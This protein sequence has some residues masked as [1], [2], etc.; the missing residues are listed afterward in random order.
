MGV[1]EKPY[2]IQ[3][4]TFLS[5]LEYLEIK[6]QQFTI[7]VIKTILLF[8]SQS[9]SKHYLLEVYDEKPK[10]GNWS[11]GVGV[12]GGFDYQDLD[13]LPC[14]P[15]MLACEEK[16]CPCKE[17]DGNGCGNG[18]KPSGKNCWK[19]YTDNWGFDFEKKCYVSAD[20]KECIK[21]LPSHP[22][23]IKKNN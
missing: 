10:N 22:D 15:W 13:D 16:Q 19:S 11:G 7:I 20:T 23:H 14:C 8:L 1:R 3:A 6:M 2:Q 9:Q 17:C 4:F 21:P 5:W 12:D 18:G